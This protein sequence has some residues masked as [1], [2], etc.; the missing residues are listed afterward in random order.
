MGSEASL[1]DGQGTRQFDRPGRREGECKLGGTTLRKLSTQPDEE[2]QSK[3][4]IDDI[5]LKGEKKLERRPSSIKSP[6][7]EKELQFE[8]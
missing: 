8:Q 5:A 7:I 6:E 4:I 1:G 3:Q 2:Q